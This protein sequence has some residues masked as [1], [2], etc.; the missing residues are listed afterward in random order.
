VSPT[1]PVPG[2]QIEAI[3][4][5]TRTQHAETASK[6]ATF[7]PDAGVQG[8]RRYRRQEEQVGEG[9]LTAR[10]HAFHVR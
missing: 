1:Q 7:G 2:A 10:T 8:E 6:M 5:L 3:E 9:L 4:N